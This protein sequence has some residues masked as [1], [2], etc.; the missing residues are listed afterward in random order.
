MR[1]I[2]KVGVVGA[3]Q[4]GAGI[5]E[6]CARAGVEVLVADPGGARPRARTE[7]DIG[8]HFF[9]PVPVMPLVEIITSLKTSPERV[10]RATD[11]VAAA[12]GKQVI[13]S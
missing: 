2:E 13:T 10:D 5:A 7:R 11:F 3:G 1:S 4:M 12:L 6:I 8:L 9:N